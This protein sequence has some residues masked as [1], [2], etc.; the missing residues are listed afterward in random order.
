MAGVISAS[1][2]T[3]GAR[4]GILS[5][6]FGGLDALRIAFVGLVFLV[7]HDLETLWARVE[8]T[9]PAFV[10]GRKESTAAIAL[11][12]HDKLALLLGFS[13]YSVKAIYVTLMLVGF[14]L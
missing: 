1:P 13:P 12:W 6:H 2:P 8:V 10:S 4:L 5:N 9:E 11:T 7:A 3:R 14:S